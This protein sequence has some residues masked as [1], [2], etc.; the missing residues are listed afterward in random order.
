VI[1]A[2]M[3]WYTTNTIVGMR[4]LPMDG[5]STA[6]RSAK[7]LRSPM[8]ALPVSENASEKPQ[9]HHWKD[10]TASVIIDAHIMLSAFF[11]RRRPA[12]DA[13]QLSVGTR[14]CGLDHAQ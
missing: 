2:N 10:T 11:R 14:A 1:A 8:Y 7:Y 4:V 3:S 9:S 5:C 13:C 12:A 6:P